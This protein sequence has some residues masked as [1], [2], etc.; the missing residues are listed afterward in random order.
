[1]TSG[2]IFMDLETRSPRD[3]RRE[4][5]RNYAGDPRSEVM[6]SVFL[7]DGE[8]TVWSPLT[9]PGTLPPEP[10]IYFPDEIAERTG[11]P[12]D[13][14]RFEL[15][16]GPGLPPPVR[17][18]L[19]APWVAHNAMGFDRLMW[20]R[21]YPAPRGW[22]D[23]LPLCRMLAL[24]AGID[25]I[26]S[27]LFGVGKDSGRA[28]MLKLS[29]PMQRGP[30]RGRF[31]PLTAHN[32]P[33]VLRY[34]VADVLILAALWRDHLAEGIRTFP[35]DLPTLATDHVINDRGITLDTELAERVIAAELDL[36]DDTASRVFERLDGALK[37]SIGAPGGVRAMLRSPVRFRAFMSE[38]FDVDL[39]D[40]K[41]ATV[42]DYIEAED[43]EPLATDLL[44][45]RINETRITSAKLQRGL[46]LVELD[47]VIRA[48]LAYYKAHTGRWAGVG[49]QFQNLPRP[50]KGVDVDGAIA[51]LM[52]F[53]VG[54]PRAI[55]AF[56]ASVPEGIEPADVL[57]ALIRA[58][59]VA[60]EGNEFV[61]ID[62]A[63][64]EARGL[65]Y[66][67]GDEPGLSVFRRGGDPYIAFA[68]KVFGVP[69]EQVT[70]VQ[71][72]AGKVGVLGCGY[73][74]SS[75]RLGFYAAGLGVDL[76]EVGTT[77]QAIVEG[78]RDANPL[79]AGVRTG[80][81]FNG[82]AVRRGG[83]WKD[84]ARAFELA[85]TGHRSVVGRCEFSKWRDHVVITLPSG[86]ALIYRYARMA[87]RLKFGSVRE[88]SVY[89]QYRGKSAM[90]V[91]TYGGKL[92]ENIVQA[93]CRDLLANA[94]NALERAGFPVSLHV[95]DEA[96]PEILRGDA[97]ALRR[98]FE[99][100]TTRPAYA[101][102]F[103]LEAEGFASPRYRK[104]PPPGER[105]FKARNGVFIDGSEPIPS[106]ARRDRG[107]RGPG[108]A[109]PHVH[110]AGADGGPPGLA[111]TA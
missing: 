103:P 76:E 43:P 100:V 47:G 109:H 69:E 111:R 26:G 59:A 73:S 61:I 83:F 99:I 24:P 51:A 71:R 45:A 44:L 8:L 15:F 25:A 36:R 31:L 86:R 67:I 87:D 57:A 28:T 30:M 79:V 38:N 21:R 110:R 98:V 12:R 74:M 41:R 63:N 48:M 91:D 4:G 102:D 53:G 7:R 23:T 19:G 10:R 35:A 50:V 6:T 58:C 22:V 78:W 77:S 84:A 94:L 75:T 29:M 60:R 42:M 3:L 82:V 54:D 27:E 108:S 65:L 97:R 62:F 96:L 14:L 5:S 17:E 92:V 11:F 107:P 90:V 13:A 52:A 70:K 80:S 56:L 55:P 85:M 34:N 104:S 68:S 88:T 1:M 33:D 40:T 93:F 106:A 18:M 20:D 105:E 16:E 95:H 32:L 39:P 64:I 9:S 66:L 49:L 72:Q 2:L 101:P 37:D 89:T 81:F 46:A